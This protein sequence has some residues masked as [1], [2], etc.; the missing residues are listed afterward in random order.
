MLNF[1]QILLQRG[2]GS[3]VGEPT[4]TRCREVPILFVP[5]HRFLSFNLNYPNPD[6]KCQVHGHWPPAWSY[7]PS[8]T[9]NV[10]RK[11]RHFTKT[12]AKYIKGAKCSV[13][14]KSS[15]NRTYWGSYLFICFTYVKES[16]GH[17]KKVH[18]INHSET[19]TIWRKVVKCMWQ[20]QNWGTLPTLQLKRVHK[21]T[22]NKDKA[23]GQCFMLRNW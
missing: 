22:G 14:T 18:L 3:L 8:S 13:K 10:L 17:S 20:K 2:T 21:T 7:L 9:I 1:I 4:C 6:R 15:Q 11:L 23:K 12:K 16:V 19:E 5:S